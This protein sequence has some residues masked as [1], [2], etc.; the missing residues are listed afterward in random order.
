M[1][2]EEGC[3]CFS[4]VNKA[5]GEAM[6]HSIGDTHPVRIFLSISKLIANFIIMGKK[7]LLLFPS[8]AL[9]VSLCFLYGYWE[10]CTCIF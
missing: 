8:S 1:K 2:D 7:N 9:L 6:K 3:P 5:T 10:K 4:L